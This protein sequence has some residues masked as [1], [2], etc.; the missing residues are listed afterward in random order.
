MSCAVGNTDPGAAASGGF[1][2]G[3]SSDGANSE[4][5]HA[6]RCVL[7]HQPSPND[8]RPTTFNSSTSRKRSLA[9]RTGTSPRNMD[10]LQ[11]S[12]F[13]VA[14]LPVRS[15]HE[16]LG[17]NRMVVPASTPRPTRRIRPVPGRC[18][19]PRTMILE[20]RSEASMRGEDGPT[21]KC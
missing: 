8:G 18:F 3:V 6:S 14:S 7:R 4:G 10:L 9:R 21:S 11:N 15:R 19:T 20:R 16:E 1:A 17:F 12:Q 2:I 13:N 5:G